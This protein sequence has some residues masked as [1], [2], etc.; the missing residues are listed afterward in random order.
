M[1]SLCTLNILQL[2][3]AQITSVLQISTTVS[4]ILS[5]CRCTWPIRL[6]DCCAVLK[7]A[8]TKGVIIVE[9]QLDCFFNHSIFVSDIKHRSK[10]ERRCISHCCL[11]TCMYQ[12]HSVLKQLSNKEILAT[13]GCQKIFYDL[14]YYRN[15]VYINCLQLSV[16]KT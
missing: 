6:I 11:Y 13:L 15:V 8:L 12:S 1:V 16:S 14:F 4:I 3:G 9:D 5:S 10:D 2:W 7:L